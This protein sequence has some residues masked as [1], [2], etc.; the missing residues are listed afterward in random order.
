MLREL[1]VEV[2]ADAGWSNL[3]AGHSEKVELRRGQSAQEYD[4]VYFPMQT[5]AP[6]AL[7]TITKNA[8]SGSRVLM[9]GEQFNP[10]TA[11]ALRVQGIDYLDLA[12]NASIQ[13]G[14]VL[15]DVRGRRSAAP[16]SKETRVQSPRN[17]FSLSRSQVIFALLTWPELLT[18]PVRYTGQVAGVSV[19]SAFNTIE[20]LKEIGYLVGEGLPTIARKRELIDNWTTAYQTG[21][22]NKLQLERFRGDIVSV[23]GIGPGAPFSISGELAV[24][25][26]LRPTTLTLYVRELDPQLIFA[27]RWRRDENPNI[28]IRRQ[29]WK[30]PAEI[31][32]AER[33]VEYERFEHE[34]PSLLVYA[35]LMSSGDGRQ[36]EAAGI[37]REQNSE[38]AGD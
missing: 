11:N 37:Y 2:R 26:L 1:G 6:S 10:R 35:D 13:F 4:A 25:S 28:E 34:V 7:R 5:G 20:F 9:F 16:R 30:T 24:P 21:L 29:F 36:R 27:N 8:Q 15:I 3:L 31:L 22:K 19:G 14:D 38:L 33:G 17:P 12:G 18:M 23:V 32:R